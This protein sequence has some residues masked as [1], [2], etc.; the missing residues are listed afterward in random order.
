[1]T[2]K[3]VLSGAG[4]GLLALGLAACGGSSS[5]SGGGPAPTLAANVAAA[6]RID[7]DPTSTGKYTPNKTTVKVG[8][9]VEWDFNDDTGGPHTATSDDGTSFDS[10]SSNVAGNKGDK[11][12]H[13]FTAAGTFAYHCT[14]HADMKGT[15][16]VEAAA[17][18]AVS[19]S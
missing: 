10:Q 15:V 16:V 18:P 7:Y 2:S 14:F 13:K 4:M 3:R 12:Q 5:A 8:D 11:F 19:P 9:T 1:M 17:A 6:V